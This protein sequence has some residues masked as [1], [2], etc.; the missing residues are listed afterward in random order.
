MFPELAG[1][2]RAAVARANGSSGASKI[3]A[4]RIAADAPVAI[5][6]AEPVTAAYNCQLPAL[7]FRTSFK[8]DARRVA[9]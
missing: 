7:R 8:E 9:K 4:P 2:G 3:P 5:A 6:I 1:R